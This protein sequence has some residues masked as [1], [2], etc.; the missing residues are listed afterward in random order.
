MGMRQ[1]ANMDPPKQQRGMWRMR[2]QTSR[3]P[4]EPYVARSD[5]AGQTPANVSGPDLGA[6]CSQQATKCCN[7]GQATQPWIT[8]HPT[9]CAA[10]TGHGTANLP[11]SKP[12]TLTELSPLQ[13]SHP[14]L[15]EPSQ[16]H[17][18]LQLR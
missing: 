6:A 2:A 10:A 3:N 7:P 5:V 1:T 4:G 15:H 18:H 9:G 16:L 11:G 14:G 12:W 17:A 13:S 8:S